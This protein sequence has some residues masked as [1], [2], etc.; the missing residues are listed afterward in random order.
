MTR[1]V[2]ALRALI[3]ANFPRRTL[4]QVKAGLAAAKTAKADAA[5]A[6]LMLRHGRLTDEA[7]DY[8]AREY[9]QPEGI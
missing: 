8:V 6:R 5:M 7:R 1:T 2:D 3:P 9:P 4:Q